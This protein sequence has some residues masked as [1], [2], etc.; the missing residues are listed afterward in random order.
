MNSSDIEWYVAESGLLEYLRHKDPILAYVLFKNVPKTQ[1]DRRKALEKATDDFIKN[2]SIS[3]SSYNSEIYVK[4]NALNGV[5]AQNTLK[6]SLVGSGNYANGEDIALLKVDTNGTDLPVLAVSSKNPE[7]GEKISIYGYPINNKSSIP[8]ESSGRLNVEAPNPQG[9]IYYE[10]NALTGEGYSGG[11]VVNVQN[12][13]IGILN[14]GVYINETSKE[15]IGSL[16]LS[17]DYIQKICKKY[18][19]Q[20]NVN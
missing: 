20:L 13:V 16:F 10:T 2:G 9:T 14:S 12:K 19:V 4:G 3:V 5:N 15:I 17:S 6:A 7:T 11:P 1:N 8:S 18:N